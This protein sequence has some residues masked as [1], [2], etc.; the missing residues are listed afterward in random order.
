MK[1]VPF[2]KKQMCSCNLIKDLEVED[3]PC[4]SGD[5]GVQSIY[6]CSLQEEVVAIREKRVSTGQAS[7]V[8]IRAGD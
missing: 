3:I 1:I 6:I 5:W 4:L 7:A 2:M 8:L